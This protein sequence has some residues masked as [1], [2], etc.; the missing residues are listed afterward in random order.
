MATNHS[1][2]DPEMVGGI[3]RTLAQVAATARTLAADPDAGEDVQTVAKMLADQAQEAQGCVDAGWEAHPDRRAVPEMMG[4]N[5]TDRERAIVAVERASRFIDE[6][7]A[8]A[9]TIHHL[10]GVLYEDYTDRDELAAIQMMAESLLG[11]AGA[12]AGHDAGYGPVD[13]Y[14]DLAELTGV[15]D[16]TPEERAEALGKGV[17]RH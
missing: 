7:A 4:T 16:C 6:S 15:H 3:M 11:K 17:P 8:A 12:D 13:S 2:S 5:L 14:Q 1:T 9:Q 10:A